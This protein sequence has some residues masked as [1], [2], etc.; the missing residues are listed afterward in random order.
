MGPEDDDGEG[1]DEYE[2]ESRPLLPPVADAVGLSAYDDDRRKQPR[3]AFAFH[4]LFVFDAPSPSSTGL[5]GDRTSAHVYDTEIFVIS[6]RD[7]VRCEFPKDEGM[8]WMQKLSSVVRP[9]KKIMEGRRSERVI[10][11]SMT[12][13][14]A[15]LSRLNPSFAV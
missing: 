5:V 1:D 8:R 11:R 4:V 14:S 10:S 7:V 6:P 3:V 9:R 12:R 2:I 15:H 13:E